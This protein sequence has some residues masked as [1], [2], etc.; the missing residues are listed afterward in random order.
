MLIM[1]GLTLR[2]GIVEWVEG[3]PVRIPAAEGAKRRRP[4]SPTC[5]GGNGDGVRARFAY[6]KFGPPDIDGACALQYTE[7]EFLRYMEQKA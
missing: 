1:L 2:L 6:L 3:G 4:D 7:L 5:G